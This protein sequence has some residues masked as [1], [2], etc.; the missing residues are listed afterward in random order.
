MEGL[1]GLGFKDMEPKGY[2]P[3]THSNF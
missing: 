2:D 3:N 1:I